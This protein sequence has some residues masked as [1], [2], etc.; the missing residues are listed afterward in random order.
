M[1]YTKSMNQRFL[2]IEKGELGEMFKRLNQS[3]LINIRRTTMNPELKRANE[4]LHVIE[5]ALA[6]NGHRP[7]TPAQSGG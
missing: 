4:P 6:G 5:C 1:K 2:R 7:G 3:Y